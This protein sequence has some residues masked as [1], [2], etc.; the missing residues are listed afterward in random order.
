MADNRITALEARIATLEA[1]PPCACLDCQA[2]R[3]RQIAESAILQQLAIERAPDA[4]AKVRVMPPRDQAIFWQRA[5]P[6]RA[7]ELLTSPEVTEEE[8]AR[9]TPVK[10]RDRLELEL[11]ELPV[12]VRLR[13]VANV[14]YTPSHI[15][16]DDD[17]ARKL[18]AVG[19]GDRLV[20]VHDVIEF[21]P[22]QVTKDF[23]P[24]VER[25]QLDA[26]LKIDTQL[27]DCL[28]AE[29]IGVDQLSEIDNRR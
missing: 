20:R 13:L 9:W 17:T 12:R 5:A 19:L 3:K 10:L 22:L 29:E 25:R 7:I 18:Q 14:R 27:S 4:I 23:S 24:V 6:E 16:V 8:R 1:V 2:W 15:V 28:A 11:V 21:V 26:M